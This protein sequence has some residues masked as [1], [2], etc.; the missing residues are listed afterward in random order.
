[1][2]LLYSLFIETN[3]VI[4]IK[5]IGMWWIKGVYDCVDLES[6]LNEFNS[7]QYEDNLVE[8]SVIAESEEDCINKIKE[9]IIDNVF[10]T[11]SQY[12]L[13]ITLSEEVKSQVFWYEE[14]LVDDF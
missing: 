5:E 10:G 12:R 9:H 8:F 13:K 2:Q 14:K 11:F 4:R 6:E 7:T 3:V 1:M